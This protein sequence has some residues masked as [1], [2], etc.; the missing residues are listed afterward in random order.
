MFTHR[1]NLQAKLHTKWLLIC[2]M[3]ITLLF[4]DKSFV[5]WLTELN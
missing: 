1:L 4:V 2:Q 5:Y 3:I